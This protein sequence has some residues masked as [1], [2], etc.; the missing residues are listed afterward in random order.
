MLETLRQLVLWQ[1][2]MQN[3]QLQLVKILP[4]NVTKALLLVKMQPLPQIVLALLQSVFHQ[5]Q[6][7]QTQQRSVLMQEAAISIA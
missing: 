3:H 1:M 2:R 6:M 4:L 5:L 7:V